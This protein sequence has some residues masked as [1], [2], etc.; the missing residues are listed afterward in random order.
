MTTLV[1]LSDGGVLCL[2]AI[3]I[4]AGEL[5]LL[6]DPYSPPYKTQVYV[7]RLVGTGDNS[8]SGSTQDYQHFLIDACAVKSRRTTEVLE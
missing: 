7:A 2:Y 5:T 3:V 1:A 8:P 6:P 4:C